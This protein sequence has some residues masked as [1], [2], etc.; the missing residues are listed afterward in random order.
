M[1]C[2]SIL[3]LAITLVV[4]VVLY[5][6]LLFLTYII[7]NVFIEYQKICIAN[8]IRQDFKMIKRI[9]TFMNAMTQNFKKD[10][11]GCVCYEKMQVSEN[12]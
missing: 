7:R 8:N 5:L 10:N 11:V 12:T 9:D 2:I 6:N 3:T 4:S 1:N